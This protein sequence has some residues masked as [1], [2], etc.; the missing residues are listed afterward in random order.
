MLYSLLTVAVGVLLGVQILVAPRRLFL[1][2]WLGWI[3]GHELARVLVLVLLL[4]IV[5][6]AVLMFF[7]ALNSGRLRRSRV[8]RSELGDIDIS[9][10]ALENIAL[11]A[12]KAAQAGVKSA[13]ARISQGKDHELEITMIVVLYTD[14]EIPR[15]WPASRIG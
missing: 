9:V 11:N 4:I 1:S 8:R 14:V 2:E 10:E 7:Y 3:A 13:K 15:R 5:L 12:S 6:A